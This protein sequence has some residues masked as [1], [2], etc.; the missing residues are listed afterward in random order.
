MGSTTKFYMCK[1]CEYVY[2][3]DKG[4][5]IHGIKKGTRFLDIPDDWVCPVCNKSK[6]FFRPM[7][8]GTDY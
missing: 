7:E 8:V 3:P 5:D 6:T 4:D 1:V 2:D